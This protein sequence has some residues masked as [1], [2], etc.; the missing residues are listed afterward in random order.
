MNEMLYQCTFFGI[1]LS[2]FTY[3]IGYRINQKF[4]LTLLNPLL[5]S[6]VLIIAVLLI[7]KID[8][9][10]YDLGAKYITYFLTPAT[11]CLAVP[12]YRQFEVLKKNIAAV[13][14][15]CLSGCIAH[16]A[17][18]IGI[19]AL[20]KVDDLLTI[21]LLPK[22]VTTAIA[23]G[24]ADEVGGLS[25][26]TV[27]GV[28]VAGLT[29]AILGPLILKLI[30]VKEPAAQGLAIGTASHALGTSKACELGEVQAAMSSL[31]IVVTGL[32]TVVIVPLLANWLN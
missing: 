14:A 2:L 7:F 28:C 29:G 31:A 32:M 10:T 30:H 15:G 12:L 17:V 18:V 5:I 13:I 16:A 6:M 4:K 27:V 1:A 22:S 20:F 11:I 21:S 24:V 9:E 25:S 26:V 23:I 3:W 19:A 8:Y